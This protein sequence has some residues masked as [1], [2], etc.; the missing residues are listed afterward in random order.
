MPELPEVETVCRQL[1]KVV[2]GQRIRYVDVTGRRTIR[3]QSIEEFVACLEGRTI[4]GVRRWG[5]YLLVEL[6]DRCVLV[7]HLRMSGQLRHETEAS[8]P[9]QIHTHVVIGF[10]DGKELR[11]VDPRTFGE[12]FV[13]DDVDARGL[14]V[15]LSHLGI[16]PV[17]D[18]LTT[19]AFT[20]LCAHR[21]LAIKALLLDQRAIAGVGNIYGDEICFMAKVRPDRRAESLTRRERERLVAAVPVILHHAITDGGSSLVDLRYRDLVGGLGTYQD[22]HQVYGRTGQGCYVCGTPI[23]KLVISGRSS[24]F[25]PRCQR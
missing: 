14:P 17:A 13:A 20:A 21:K 18:E 9:R 16:D 8:V 22:R 4:E 6:D 12:L 3:R 1:A 5:K 25:C 24:H 19:V 23:R 15:Q 11:F 2:V 10:D 7:I